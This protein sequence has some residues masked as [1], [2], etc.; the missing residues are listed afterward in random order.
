MCVTTIYS[1]IFTK[2]FS[3][4]AYGHPLKM[5]K[6][7]EGLHTVFMLPIHSFIDNVSIRT[8]QTRSGQTNGVLTSENVHVS[9]HMTMTHG[10]CGNNSINF[11]TVNP[12]YM[13]S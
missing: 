12:R 10:G 11:L 6:E 2:M 4:A 7:Q 5:F 1:N 3:Y 9:P 8:G 13:W